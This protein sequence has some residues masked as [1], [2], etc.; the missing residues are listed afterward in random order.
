LAEKG[1]KGIFRAK[2]RTWTPIPL[3]VGIIA[4]F[5]RLLSDCS[6]VG[7]APL[8]YFGGGAGLVDGRYFRL[9]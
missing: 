4:T 2:I 7:P 9:L 3:K 5:K 1:K 6:Q 8:V